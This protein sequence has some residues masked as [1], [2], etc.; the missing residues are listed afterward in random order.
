[1]LEP[2]QVG[3]LS[4]SDPALTPASAPLQPVFNHLGPCRKIPWSTSHG[5]YL[6]RF[7]WAS[8]FRATLGLEIELTG[9]SGKENGN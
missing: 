8:G 1:M 2:E 5:I 7:R 4:P 9:S 6:E 3:K